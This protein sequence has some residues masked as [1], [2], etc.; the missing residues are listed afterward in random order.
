MC[1]GRRIDTL[2]RLGQPRHD[3]AG[4]EI[5]VQIHQLLGRGALADRE[6]EHLV[7][8]MEALAVAPEDLRRNAH[9]SYCLIYCAAARIGTCAFKSCGRG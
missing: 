2:T 5:D 7:R 9:P 3:A 4:A 1:R 6:A 8:Q